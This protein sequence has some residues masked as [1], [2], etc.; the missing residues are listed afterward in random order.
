MVSFSKQ[1]RWW[2]PQPHLLSS[3]NLDSRP[4]YFHG[5]GAPLPDRHGLVIN[6]TVVVTVWFGPAGTTGV[7]MKRGSQGWHQ[8]TTHH[9]I[10]EAITRAKSADS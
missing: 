4:R 1:G 3:P 7:S 9:P 10:K 8:A 6:V 2:W 5:P